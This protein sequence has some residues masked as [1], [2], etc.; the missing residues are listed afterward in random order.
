[1]IDSSFGFDTIKEKLRK[2]NFF[3][4]YR[5]EY[6]EYFPFGLIKDSSPKRTIYIIAFFPRKR[7]LLFN[8]DY[9]KIGMTETRIA[10][11]LLEEAKERKW[12]ETQWDGW[13][14]GTRPEEYPKKGHAFWIKAPNIL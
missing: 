1:M 8:K 7:A 9:E 5:W 3:L 10:R 13:T 11:Q 12:L 14:G 6:K 4:P 2:K